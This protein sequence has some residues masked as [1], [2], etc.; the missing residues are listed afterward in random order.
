M[1][2]RAG[3]GRAADPAT[4]LRAVNEKGASVPTVGAAAAG[5]A[6]HFACCRCAARRRRRRLFER[7][8]EDRLAHEERCF[9][10]EREGDGVARPGVDLDGAAA[11][12]H[13]ARVEDAARE[14]AHHDAGDRAL[15]PVDEALGEVVGVGARRDDGASRLTIEFASG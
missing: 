10:A 5:A 9:E 11:G 13:D 7:A 14:V 15:E 8:L 2:A 4:G 1:C 6:H 12:E 3:A